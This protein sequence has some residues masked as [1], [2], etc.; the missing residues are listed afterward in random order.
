EADRKGG[1]L[2]RDRRTGRLILREMT[3]VREQDKA[4][5]QNISRHPYFNTNSMWIRIDALREKLEQHH[6]V[7]P[8]PVIVNHKTVDPTDLTSQKVIQLETAMGSA[9]SLFDG[10]ICVQVDRMRFLPVK[11]TNDL[12]VMRSDRFHLTDSFEMEDGD[13]HLP[14]IDL[15]DR[16]YRN[17][18]DFDERFP[19]AVPSLGAARSVTIH[20]DWTFGRNV[21]M[22]GDARLEDMGHPSYV[23]DGQFVGPQGIEPDDWV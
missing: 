3:Q 12:F 5:A 13:Y 6:G 1:H 20:G 7:L 2:V 10:A 8:L 22:Y 18:A 16:Y 15:D 17:I 19:Y 14:P 23:P 9:I 21:V 11:T 4:H